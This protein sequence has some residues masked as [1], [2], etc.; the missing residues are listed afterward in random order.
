MPRFTIARGRR[1]TRSALTCCGLFAAS[2]SAPLRA[3]DAPPVR[4]WFAEINR[5]I[6]TPFLAGVR[7]DADSLYL[8][9]RSRDYVRIQGNGRLILG[10]DDYVD[11]TQKMM[12]R[13]REQGTRITMDVRFED[14]ITDGTAASERGISRVLFSARDGE[15]RTYYS[16]FHTISRKEGGVWRVLTDYSPAASDSVGEAEFA[17]AKALDDVGDFLCYMAYPDKRQRCGR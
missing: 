2:G 9:V 10:Y 11:D 15:T 16:R 14:R 8:R 13:Y 17:R 4:Q 12:Q 7:T 3:Q 5:D 6:W 1:V